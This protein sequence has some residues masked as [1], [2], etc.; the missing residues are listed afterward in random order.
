MRIKVILYSGRRL[1]LASLRIPKD[2][3]LE[4]CLG[5]VGEGAVW[6]TTV[7]SPL[8]CSQFVQRSPGV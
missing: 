4:P 1:G 2:S 3:S 6:G 8:F 7:D 5:A